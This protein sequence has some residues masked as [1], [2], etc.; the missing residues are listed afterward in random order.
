MKIAVFGGAGKVCLGAIHDFIDNEDVEEVVLADLNFTALEERKKSL[1][2]N[3]IKIRHIDLNNHEL[4]VNLLDDYDVC[5]NGSSHHFNMK[6]MKVCIDSKT[7][8]SE[9]HTSEL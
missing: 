7:N 4:M 9:E 1:D 5:L 8:R 2:S 6:V 3:K